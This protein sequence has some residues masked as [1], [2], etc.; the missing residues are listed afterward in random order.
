MWNVPAGGVVAVA[1][2][3]TGVVP[4]AEAC[5]AWLAAEGPSRQARR[6]ARPSKSVAWVPPLI[7]PSPCVIANVTRAPATGFPWASFT[8]TVGRDARY[9][10]KKPVWEVGDSAIIAAG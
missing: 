9:F 2:K 3:D 6:P 8:W 1:E 5:T 4:P 7:V 10:P